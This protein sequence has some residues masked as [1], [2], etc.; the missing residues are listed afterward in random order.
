MLVPLAIS[1]K[2]AIG[3]IVVPSTLAIW[4][5]LRAERRDEAR[6]QAEQARLA[7][8]AK[9]AAGSVDGHPPTF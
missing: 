9:Q 2:V 7:A 8:Q 1:G 6:E 3:A 4:L 5:L